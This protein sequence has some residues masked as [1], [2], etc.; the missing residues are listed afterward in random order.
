VHGLATATGEVTDAF[1]RSRRDAGK[2]HP[3]TKVKDMTS[4]TINSDSGP[5]RRFRLPAAVVGLALASLVAAAPSSA[6]NK[7]AHH[8]THSKSA[9]SYKVDGVRAW[10]KHGTLTVKGGNRGDAIALRLAAGDSSR[11]QVDVGDDGSADF[12][13][14]RNHVS[15]INVRGRNGNDSLR[16]DDA[17][18]AFTDSIPTTI[19][20]GAGNDSLE[21]GQTQVAAENETFNGGPGDDVVDGGKGNDTAYL[22]AGND[23]FRWDPG[24]GS[25]VI[26]GQEGTDTMLFNGAAANETVTMTANGGRLT[27]F[28][29]PGAVTMD[30]DGVEVVDFNALG[31]VDSVTVDDLTGTDVTQTNVDLASALGG[32]NPDSAVDSVDLNG[33]NGVDNIDI[34]GNGSGADVTGLATAVSVEHADTSDHLNVHT[35]GGADN[36]VQNVGGLIQLL[37]D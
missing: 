35:L 16:I 7:S 29:Q 36:V 13:F 21:G 30:T 25:D 1:E 33:T 20:G 17:N 19:S 24:E 12:S 10:V 31:G 15:A 5:R 8:K 14:A 22:G 34:Q 23:T 3:Q 18:G 4:P 27:F 2:P 9:H 6:H 37:V 28:R 32:V 11:I 26:E